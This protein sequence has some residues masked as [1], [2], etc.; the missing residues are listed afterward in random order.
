[1]RKTRE[2]TGPYMLKKLQD[3]LTGHPLV[4]EIRAKGLI[5]AIELNTPKGIE[6]RSDKA[7]KL[8]MA[9]RTAMFED[10]AI[11]RATW[12]TMVYSPPLIITKEE[13]DILVG[14]L[15]SALDKVAKEQKAAA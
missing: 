8:G 5:G 6:K 11:M 1:M 10:G 4:G 7:G 3:T 13:I 15:K 14:K 12:D 9:V 2:E